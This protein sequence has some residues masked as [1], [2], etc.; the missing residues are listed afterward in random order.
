[1]IDQASILR[2]SMWRQRQSTANSTAVPRRSVA[3]I[4]GKGGVGTTTVAVQLATAWAQHERHVCIVDADTDRNDV[5]YLLHIPDHELSLPQRTPLESLVSSTR[6]SL[7]S[8]P[9][10]ASASSWSCDP[11]RPAQL[12]SS[13]AGLTASL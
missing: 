10:V 11:T 1:M 7:P 5:A 6:T 13:T 12:R 4:A 2:Q 8:G 9:H 3:V